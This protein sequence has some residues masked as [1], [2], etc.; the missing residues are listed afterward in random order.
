MA[1]EVVA[2]M[3]FQG[4]VIGGINKKRGVITGSDSSEGYFTIFCEVSHTLPTLT[5]YMCVRV[6]LYF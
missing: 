2:P 5:E 4:T 1:V 3:E 6:M